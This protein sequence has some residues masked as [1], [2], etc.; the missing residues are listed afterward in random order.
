MGLCSSVP[1]VTPADVA[2][3]REIL[4]TASND[5]ERLESRVFELSELDEVEPLHRDIDLAERKINREWK[6]VH[7]KLAKDKLRKKDEVVKKLQDHGKSW[8]QVV[9]SLSAKHSLLNACSHSTAKFVANLMSKF[10][11]LEAGKKSL[12]LFKNAGL[13]KR[14]DDLEDEADALVSF[15]SGLGFSPT[16]PRFLTLTNTNSTIWSSAPRAK[17]NSLRTAGLCLFRLQT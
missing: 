14:A 13:S 1:A 3:V 9:G 17:N 5:L 12:G 6:L 8:V 4:D 10:K 2:Y 7:K 16:A 15:C 11:R